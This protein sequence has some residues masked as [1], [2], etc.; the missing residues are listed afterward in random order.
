MILKARWQAGDGLK[1][2]QLRTSLKEMQRVG[3][4][5]SGNRLTGKLTI[6]QVRAAYGWMRQ[7][8]AIKVADTINGLTITITNYDTFQAPEN[9][10]HHQKPDPTRDTTPEPTPD[11]ITKQ[12]EILGN[13]RVFDESQIPDHTSDTTPEPARNPHYLKEGK[14]IKTLVASSSSKRPPSGDH[15]VFITWWSYA[16]SRIFGKTYTITAKDGSAVKNLLRDHPIRTLILAACYLLTTGDQFLSRNRTLSGLQS[17]I[18]NING[19]DTANDPQNGK[20]YRALGL[21]PPEGVL[22]ED[23]HFWEP[24]E[25]H[26][27]AA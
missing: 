9:P 14:N 3:E 27:A 4:Y 12:R 22:L 24:K 18:N 23:W 15:Q 19:S 25:N 20:R 2:G 5:K 13:V 8:G 26:Y 11:T 10:G 6:D 7:S 17:S 16:F 21:L 1:R